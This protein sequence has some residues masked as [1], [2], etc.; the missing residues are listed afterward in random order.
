MLLAREF[1][2]W[3][4][5]ANAVAWPVAYLAMDRWL[6][7]FAYRITF[8]PGIFLASGKI[9]VGVAML[10]ISARTVQAASANPVH[11]QRYEKGRAPGRRV[12]FFAIIDIA[13]RPKI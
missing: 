1:T 13:T 6:R 10:T 7:A 11:L 5:Q 12:P 4:L 2:R 9:A 3:V 8:G